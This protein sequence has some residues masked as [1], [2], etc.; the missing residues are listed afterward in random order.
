MALKEQAWDVM[1]ITNLKVLSSVQIHC[2]LPHSFPAVP[3]Q[4]MLDFPQLELMSKWP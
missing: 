1:K 3:V 4:E 2:D